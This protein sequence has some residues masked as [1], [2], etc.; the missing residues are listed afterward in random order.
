MIDRYLCKR[1]HPQEHSHTFL[2]KFLKYSHSCTLFPLAADFCQHSFFFLHLFLSNPFSLYLFSAVKYASMFGKV[3]ISM[4]N[5][6][7]FLNRFTINELGTLML[8]ISNCTPSAPIS[9][10]PSAKL[11][12]VS[13]RIKI[14]IIFS[15]HEGNGSILFSGRN[16]TTPGLIRR[17][18][19]NQNCI[20]LRFDRL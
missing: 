20:K 7:A 18:Q 17:T 10:L 11:E 8:H 4:C 14:E 1:K 12:F 13:G 16:R 3:R 19:A 9:T 2:V 5:P 15:T 6:V